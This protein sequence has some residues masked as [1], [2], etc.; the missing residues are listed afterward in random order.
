MS[1]T[2]DT[3]KTLD[4]PIRESSTKSVSHVVVGI[5]AYNEEH[6]IAS[7]VLGA[8][9]YVDRVIVVD[10]GS[11][12]KTAERARQA[13]ATV[14]QHETNK[15]KGSAIKTLFTYIDSLEWDVLVVLDGDGQHLPSD[16]PTVTEP[17]LKNDA[18]I[19]IGSRYL[20]QDPENETP[21]Y[22]RFG[23]RVLDLLT[24]G[25][26][27]VKLTD[28]QSGFRAFSP[29]TVKNLPLRSNGIC[30]ES[31]MIDAAVQQGLRIK[32]T[33]IDIRYDGVEGQTYNPLR[34]GLSV[35][36]FFLRLVRDRHPL[37]FFGVPGALLTLAGTM[38]GIDAILVYQQTGEFYPAKV[39]VSGFVTIIGI[40]GVFCGLIL[41]QIS[42]I[43]AEL[44]EVIEE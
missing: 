12:D 22:R 41:N 14:I 31:E 33:P 7:T 16:I 37:L 17:I 23:Q 2:I 5:P 44:T 40:L 39:L 25:S 11:T 18:D 10:D 13:G 20:E 27:G 35:V 38:Y 26:T 9:K 21:R 1:K 4:G 28:T 32:E 34:H 30:V 29:A 42:A 15:G 8:K 6:A 43:I 24:T 3:A 19:S 36:A